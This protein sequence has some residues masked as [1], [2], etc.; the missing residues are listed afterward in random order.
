VTTT[1]PPDGGT[2]SPP[3]PG[4]YDY[5]V[6]FNQAVDSG[7]VQDSDLQL[8]GNVGGTVTGH[9]LE[10]GN[11]TIHFTVHFNNG[12]S[13]TASIGA[14]AI[15][16]NGCNVNAA[17]SGMYTVEGPAPCSWGAAA[18]LP[19][20]GVRQVGVNFPDNGKFYSMG[21]RAFD[22]G[23]GE[24]TH[25]FEYD[26][27]GNSWTTKA[28]T[29]PDGN[30]N[31]MACGVLNDAG[32]NYIYCVGGSQSGVN[33]VTGRVFRYNPVTDTLSTVAAPWPPGV[34]TLPG[35]FSIFNNK[36][37]IL[38]GFDNP[39]TGNSTNQ[40][41]EFTPGINAWM[42]KS[43]VLPV[44][45]AY[46]PT[47]TIGSLIYTGGGANIVAGALTP[48]TDSFVY[49]PVADS[50][51][52]IAN[53]PRP[54][55]NTRG[56]N[57]CNQLYVLGGDD[58]TFPNPTNEVDI[59]DPVSNTWSLGTPMITARR[60]FATDTDGT[61]NIWAAGGYDTSGGPT[62]LTENFNCPVSPCAS[63][64]PTPTATATATATATPTPTATPA[65]RATPTPRP[66]PT[67]VPR[68]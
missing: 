58:T 56:L 35:G 50:I 63:P 9:T 17:F 37:Y 66:R 45:R 12:G 42:Q 7:S 25:P 5:F 64:S 2:F 11:T 6:N 54:T 62:D 44:P 65:P 20:P 41:W 46:I 53:I 4:T 48:T 3:A 31:N 32:T 55:D 57:F 33:T 67:P 34:N 51:N 24:F 47:T 23:G 10:N 18:A 43:A 14:G 19:T 60:N 28:A 21:G 26:P 13:V 27:I 8:T 16:A 59:Y 68:P 1:V 39:P 29:Y 30:V 52:T 36:F 49:D 40:I 38:G 61:I 22:G 15:T